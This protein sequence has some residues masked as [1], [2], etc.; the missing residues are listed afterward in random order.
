[1]VL[2]ALGFANMPDEA[3]IFVGTRDNDGNMRL[4][5]ASSPIPFAYFLHEKGVSI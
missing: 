1:M 5:Y 2:A 3:R 4:K